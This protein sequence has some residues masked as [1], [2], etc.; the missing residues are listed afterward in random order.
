MVRDFTLIE[1]LVVIG[2]IGILAGLVLPALSR[3][4]AEAGSTDCR[5]NLRQV[6]MMHIFYA[7]NSQGALC[8]AVDSA[9]CQWDSSANHRDPGILARV[10]PG[11]GAAEEKVFNCPDAESS[12]LYYRSSYTAK[13][14]GF[15]YNFLL[16]YTDVNRRTLA[17]FRKLKL[18]SIRRPTE[19]LLLADAAYFS[20]IER[21]SPTAFLYPPSSK[22]GGY[23]DFRHLKSA[24][25]AYLD[26][27]VAKETAFF[28]AVTGEYKERLGYLSE[29]D[30]KYDPFRK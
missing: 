11:A 9:G 29:D 22:S 2:I 15:G 19:C 12:G 1:L 28:P 14:A 20:G 8:P 10:V 18:T 5:N 3:A 7:E 25:A 26:G 16:S 24:N 23:A 30:A 17:D 21:I 4:R 13:F 27:H 6:G